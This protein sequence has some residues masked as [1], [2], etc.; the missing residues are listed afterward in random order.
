MRRPNFR[1]VLSP[2]SEADL[3]AIWHW[4]AARFSPD[5]A[6]AHLRDIQ[7]SVAALRT[8]PFLAKS[9]DDLLPG[10]RAFVVYPTVVFYRVAEET[11][12]IVRVIDGRRNLAAIF[13]TTAMLDVLLPASAFFIHARADQSGA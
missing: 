4:G 6:D 9:R 8:T 12:D 11:V 10:V 2:E 5:I 7:K 1:I 13:L 3:L